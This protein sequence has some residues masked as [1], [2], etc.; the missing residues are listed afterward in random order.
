[1]QPHVTQALDSWYGAW[2]LHEQKAQDA[3]AA[4]F[5]ALNPATRCQCFGPTL[6]WVTPGE[7]EG[8][9]CLDDHGRATIEFEKV[10]KA[11]VGAAMT[12][13]WGADWFD[14]GPGGFAEAEPGTYH[15]ED[16]QTYAEYEFDVGADGTVT[17]GISYVKVDDIV[18][19][20][21]ALE[22]ALANQRPA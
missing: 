22:R 4:A 9:V 20:L 3:F 21:D 6:R 18:T 15:Y 11:A 16:E 5:P 19:M 17:F 2:K 10:P 12:E 8:K 7:G 14:E 13:C 1:M